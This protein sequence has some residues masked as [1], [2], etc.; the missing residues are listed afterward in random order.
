MAAGPRSCA[1]SSATSAL[2]QRLMAAPRLRWATRRHTPDQLLAYI[3]QERALTAS[4]QVVAAVF[5]PHAASGQRSSGS[6]P[7]RVQCELGIAAFSAGK[8]LPARLR[9]FK[10]RPLSRELHR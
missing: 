9:Q 1:S 5:G 10:P 4:V 2:C 7:A 6:E 8:L 3:A